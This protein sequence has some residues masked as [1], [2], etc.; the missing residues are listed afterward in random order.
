MSSWKPIIQESKLQS[1]KVKTLTEELFKKVPFSCEKISLNV[2][3][4]DFF[5]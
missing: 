4:S 3:I 2:P 1:N 5:G